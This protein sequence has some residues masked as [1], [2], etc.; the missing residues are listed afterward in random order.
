VKSDAFERPGLIRAKSIHWI[1]NSEAA[2]DPM[3]SNSWGWRV[4]SQVAVNERMTCE[5]R[6]GGN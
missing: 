6:A 1:C 4:G 3:E 5:V 2:G